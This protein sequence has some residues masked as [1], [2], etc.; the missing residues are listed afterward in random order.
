MKNNDFEKFESFIKV[1]PEVLKIAD[2][3]KKNPGDVLKFFVSLGTETM[4]RTEQKFLNEIEAKTK[5]YF[6]SKKISISPQV[7]E[8]LDNLIQF[9]KENNQVQ[10]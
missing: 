5:I 8:S 9:L 6:S 4:K 2:E 3:I 1:Y 7:V 10:K